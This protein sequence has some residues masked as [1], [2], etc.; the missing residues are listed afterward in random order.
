[1]PGS[2]TPEDTSLIGPGNVALGS[3][4]RVTRDDGA[5]WSPATGEPTSYTNWA[6]GRPDN[7]GGRENRIQLFGKGTL[8]S[9]QWNDIAAPSRPPCF[10]WPSLVGWPPDAPRAPGLLFDN[11]S[12]L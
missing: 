7:S 10:T 4:L 1:L 11:T 12:I 6:E 3:L 5:V 9:P 8:K 2:F